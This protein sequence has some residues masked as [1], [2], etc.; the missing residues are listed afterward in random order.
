MRVGSLMVLAM[1]VG[2]CSAE[3]LGQS[4]QLDASVGTV[5]FHIVTPTTQSFCD[6]IGPCAGGASHV[7]VSTAAGT[8]L[9]LTASSFCESSCPQSGQCTQ[10]C[11][12]I[13]C[14][15]PGEGSAVTSG[16]QQW[17]G[18]YYG[19]SVCGATCLVPTYAPAGQYVAQFGATPGTL[20]SPDAGPPTCTTT[21]SVECGPSVP[22]NFPSATPVDLTLSSLNPRTP[23]I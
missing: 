9:D 13:S 14:I 7:V 21:G 11:L 4:G 5:T 19:P 18:V 6:Q 10:R 17:S 16:D 2:A 3:N 1:A 15:G 20:S 22:F 8:T 12:S 23:R